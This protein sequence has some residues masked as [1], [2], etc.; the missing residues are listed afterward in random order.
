MADLNSSNR[1]QLPP[2]GF[3]LTLGLLLVL[4]GTA[5]LLVMVYGPSSQLRAPRWEVGVVAVPFILA[6]LKFLEAGAV[7]QGWIAGSELRNKLWFALIV[8]VFAI[9]A[10]CA[11]LTPGDVQVSAGHSTH[12]RVQEAAGPAPHGFGCVKN[13]FGHTA[14]FFGAL[15]TTAI[16]IGVWHDFI[17]RLRDNPDVSNRVSGSD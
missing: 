5:I 7:K 10:W 12:R 1:N 13:I 11:A 9:G 3:S 15:I 4:I 14:F 6:G 16:G 2:S 8:T 17:K